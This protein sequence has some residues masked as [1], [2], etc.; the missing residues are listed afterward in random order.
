MTIV[1]SYSIPAEPS[2]WSERIEAACR[3]VEGAFGV[4]LAK[5][6]AY[7]GGQAPIEVVDRQAFLRKKCKSKTRWLHLFSDAPSGPAPSC[8]QVDGYCAIDGCGYRN[9]GVYLFGAQFPEVDESKLESLFVALGDAVSAYSAHYS[10]IH[11]SR[12]LNAIHWRPLVEVELPPLLARHFEPWELRL[13]RLDHALYQGLPSPLQPHGLGWLNYWSAET[14]GY[15][16]FPAPHRDAN[17]LR[18]AYRTPAGAWL[19]KTCREPLDASRPDHIERLVE[20]YERFPRLGVR[21]KVE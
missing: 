12:R 17:L 20:A 13:P 2:D 1:L 7:R 19:V 18:N 11:T 14:A 21:A 9:K 4:K 15:I 16:G 3:L 10:P 5:A 8:P 6:T